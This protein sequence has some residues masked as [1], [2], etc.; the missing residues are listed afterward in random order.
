MMKRPMMSNT[1]LRRGAITLGCLVT[2]LLIAAALYFGIPAAESY[3]KYLEYKD[4]MA[5]EIRFHAKVPDV[6]IKAHLAVVADSLGL[7]EDAGKVTVTRKSGRLTIASEY[8]QPFQLPGI[9]KYVV[10]R[11]SAAGSY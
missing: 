2:L 7:P 4:A 8:E 3:K 5:Q 9:V 1:G 6:Q 10:L 11:P